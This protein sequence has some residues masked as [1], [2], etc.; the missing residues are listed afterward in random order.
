MKRLTRRHAL[1]FGS[2]ALGAAVAGCSSL[3]VGASEPTRLTGIRVEN[4]D[5]TA[6]TVHVL[7]LDGDDP[8]YWDSVAADAYSTDRDRGDVTEFEGVPTELGAVVVYAWRDDQPRDEWERFDF[9]SDDSSCFELVV[10]I[11][12]TVDDERGEITILQTDEY[13]TANECASES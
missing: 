12:Y 7:L 6:R 10:G 8:V 4:R 9:G 11:G 3:G 5:P 13:T 1:Q 2:V